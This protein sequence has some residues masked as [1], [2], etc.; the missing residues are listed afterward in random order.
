MIEILKPG[1]LTTVQDYPGRVGYWDVGIPPSGPMDSLS[2]R[3]A[4]RLVGNSDTEAGLEISITGPTLK[5]NQDAVIALTGSKIKAD[6]D[7]VE[8]SFNKPIQVKA[9]QVLSLG[10]PIGAGYRTY[11]A[12]AGGIDVPDYLGSKSTFPAGKFGGYKG[13]AL[14]KGDRIDIGT[15]KVPFK[16]REV[17]EG[18]VPAYSSHWELKAIPGPHSAPDYFTPDDVNMFFATDWKL[19]FQSNRMGC[20]LEGP[21]PKFARRNGGEGGRHPSNLHDY[22]YSVGTVNFTGNMPIIL[23][24]DGPSLGGFVCMATIIQSDLWKA[25]Q[26]KPNDTIRFIR[27]TYNQAL[28]VRAQ[29]DQLL[30][31][32]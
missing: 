11:F 26:A 7:S 18:L 28:E 19:H 13:R 16:D 2:F 14:Q 23:T 6:L 32:I 8:V 17:P 5:F 21:A 4:N 30:A 12:I 10:N 25:G 22:V 3:I 27:L 31:T 29:Q 24:Q 1:L 15:S 20:R 9:G